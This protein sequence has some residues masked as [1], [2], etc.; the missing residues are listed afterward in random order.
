[1]AKTHRLCFGKSAP[2]FIGYCPFFW[3]T[4]LCILLMP[5]LLP[6]RLVILI[7]STIWGVFGPGIRSMAMMPS[8][9][10]LVEFY[11]GYILSEGTPEEILQEYRSNAA[12]S[13]LY[14]DVLDWIAVTPDWES[15][16]PGAMAR[17]EKAKQRQEQKKIRRAKRAAILSKIANYSGYVIKPIL[18]ASLVVGAY[19]VIR[20]LIYIIGV[21]PLQI[22]LISVKVLIVV[23]IATTFCLLLLEITARVKHHLGY[24]P[25]GFWA[26]VGDGIMWMFHPVGLALEFIAETIAVIYTRHCPLIEWDDESGPIR[27]N[28]QDEIE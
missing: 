26:S 18:I 24:K 27:E 7:F 10:Q 1:M 23:I 28:W 14:E 4:W 25:S 16:M 8:D 20:G 9:R 17:V 22:W 5:V 6:L 21:I 3:F 19:Y 11:E 12:L 13:M 2:H 15:Y